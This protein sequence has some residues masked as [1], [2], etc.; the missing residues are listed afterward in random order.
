MNIENIILVGIIA[1]MIAMLII[2]IIA[3]IID[4]IQD[5]RLRKFINKK[6]DKKL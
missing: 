1:A 3:F 4:I 6:N 2:A 5:I